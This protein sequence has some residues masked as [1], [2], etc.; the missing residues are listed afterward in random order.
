M[1]TPRTARNVLVI[2]GGPAAHR[3]TEALA[4]RAPQDLS[5][6]VL[7]EETHLPYDRVALSQALTNPGVDLTLG[8]P[9][10]WEAAHVTL[11]TNA[12]AIAIDSVKRTV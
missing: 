10:L 2:G 3:F 5:I 6:T 9:K 8:D 4:S 12:K 11:E 7:T 1:G